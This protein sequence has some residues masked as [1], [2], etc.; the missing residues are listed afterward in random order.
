MSNIKKITSNINTNFNNTKLSYNTNQTQNSAISSI[1]K[2]NKVEE[3]PIGMGPFNIGSL[4]GI[5]NKGSK[6]DPDV[7]NVLLREIQDEFDRGNTE[8]YNFLEAIIYTKGKYP[9]L[10]FEVT[11]GNSTYHVDTNTVSINVNKLN[12]HSSIFHESGH[13]LHYLNTNFEC[14]GKFNELKKI[15]RGSIEKN[16]VS[17]L[18][19]YFSNQYHNSLDYAETEY[20]KYIS[21]KY[22]MDKDQFL[23]YLT[24]FYADRTNNI[25]EASKLAK[26]SINIEI[27]EGAKSYSY[28]NGT[29]AMGDILDAV[30]DGDL[31]GAHKDSQGRIF[32]ISGHGKDYY[33]A[34]VPIE[35]QEMFGAD[36]SRGYAEI[37][38]NYTELRVSGNTEALNKLKI[39]LGDELYNE[40]EKTYKNS[41]LA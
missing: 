41:L 5:L 35:I 36:Y 6:S 20:W 12:S 1:V 26:H 32:Q 37:I 22:N 27:E 4:G 33:G 25:N 13:M 18:M 16:G 3:L 24:S 39:F 7:V 2:P 29:M 40:V 21:N 23:K 30:F 34:T 28:S 15:A 9:N 31:H 8:A 10:T 17:K 14:S 38:S 11:E 19:D